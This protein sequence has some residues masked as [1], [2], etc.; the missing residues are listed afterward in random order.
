V[1]AYISSSS[2]SSSSEPRVEGRVSV[3]GISGTDNLISRL[4]DSCIPSLTILQRFEVAVRVEFG[5]AARVAN[6]DLGGRDGLSLLLGWPFVLSI[7]NYDWVI[8]AEMLTPSVHRIGVI[9][10]FVAMDSIH[11][12]KLALI[13]LSLLAKDIV[14]RGDIDLSCR[15]RRW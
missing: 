7:R 1:G 3:F 9:L 10:T 11:V 12:A 15:N 13:Q 5:P 6:P 4:V 2:S 14:S 8:F